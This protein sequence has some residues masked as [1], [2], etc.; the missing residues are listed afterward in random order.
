ML[1]VEIMLVHAN[2]TMANTK[3][4]GAIKEPKTILKIPSNE[5]SK[6]IFCGHESVF[7]AT[8]FLINVI[9]ASHLQNVELKFFNKN[10]V[11][12][13]KPIANTHSR[14]FHDRKRSLKM[15]DKLLDIQAMNQTDNVSK[16]KFDL[17]IV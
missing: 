1:V 4:K 6:K 5:A 9:F 14:N 10:T 17:K 15:F 7:F 8:K 2:T 3:I 16:S 11:V 12:A 13:K